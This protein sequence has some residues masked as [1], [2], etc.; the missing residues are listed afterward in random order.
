M[1][2][3]RASPILTAMMSNLSTERLMLTDLFVYPDLIFAQRRS[4][5]VLG[6]D[7][8]SLLN[9]CWKVFFLRDWGIYTAY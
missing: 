8:T 4:Y 2:N 6:G 5:M 3:P 7:V 9:F 1:N